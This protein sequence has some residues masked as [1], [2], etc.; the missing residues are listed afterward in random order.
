MKH[1]L[2]LLFSTVLSMTI[3]AQEAD[4]YK[5]VTTSFTEYFN[6][7]D[8]AA[9]FELYTPETQNDITKEGVAAFVK[10]CYSQ[11]GKLTQTEFQNTSGKVHTY[12]ATFEK[13]SLSMELLLDDQDKI[14]SIQF[15]QL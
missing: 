8:A 1:T 14:I 6:Q 7:Q 13:A 10:G 9:I 15:D 12:T 3:T 4:A 2:I 5:K 11:F